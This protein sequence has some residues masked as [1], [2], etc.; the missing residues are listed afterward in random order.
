MPKW[1]LYWVT[2]PSP[3]EDCFVVAKSPRSAA[4]L[5]EDGSGFDVGDAQAEMVAVVPDE[6]EEIAIK[7]YRT[8]LNENGSSN[9]KPRENI[10]PWPDYAREWLLEK[11]GAEF[12]IQNGREVTL[13]A[14]RSYGAAAFDE[15]FFDKKPTLIKNLTDVLRRV[16]KQEKGKWLYRGHSDAGWELKCGLDRKECIS[17]WGKLSRLEYEHHVLNQFKLRAIPYL[18]MIPQTDWEWLVLAQHYGLPTRLLDW[19]TNPLIAVFFALRDVRDGNDAAIIAYKHN[20]PP[21]SFREIG[22]FEIDKIELFEPPHIGE[23]VAAQHSVFTAEPSLNELDDSTGREIEMWFVPSKFAGKIRIELEKFGITES[24]L[25]P[26]LDSIAME[27]K[28][29]NWG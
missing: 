9:V 8:W 12:K 6:F 13:I 2:T 20:N 29:L 3:D 24:S 19:T 10:S 22:P 23:R 11:I 4:R 7:L 26:G 15:V 1:K 27:V 18:K 5:E 21:V 28:K 16:S 14:G 25:F 17:H